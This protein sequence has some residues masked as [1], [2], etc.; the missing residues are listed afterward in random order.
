MVVACSAALLFGGENL[1]SSLAL[2]LAV[3]AITLTQMVLNQQRR[4]EAA[5]HLKLD[6]LIRSQVEA[7][8]SLAGIEQKE[9]AELEAIR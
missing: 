7:D 2:I 1:E 3:L 5:L 4:S 6:E 9:V 8:D